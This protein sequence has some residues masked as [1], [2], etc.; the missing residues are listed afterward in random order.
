MANRASTD[1][2]EGRRTHPAPAVSGT[3]A[4][5]QAVNT[6]STPIPTISVTTADHIPNDA[7][8]ILNI[9]LSGSA[10]KVAAS[11]SD[12]I[13]MTGNTNAVDVADSADTRAIGLLPPPQQSGATHAAQRPFSPP[14]FIAPL[15]NTHPLNPA[16]TL[17]TLQPQYLPTYLDAPVPFTL[18]TPYHDRR[19]HITN[20]HNPNIVGYVMSHV[21]AHVLDRPVPP[22]LPSVVPRRSRNANSNPDTARSND[23]VNAVDATTAA[24]R[25]GRPVAQQRPGTTSRGTLRSEMIPGWDLS[26]AE[27]RATKTFAERKALSTPKESVTTIKGKGELCYILTNSVVNKYT[28]ITEKAGKGAVE[29]VENVEGYLGSCKFSEMCFWRRKEGGR[30]CGGCGEEIGWR[31]DLIIIGLCCTLG[32]LCWDCFKEVSCS[33][34]SLFR[35][36]CAIFSCAR[37]RLIRAL[38]KLC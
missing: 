30:W 23:V 15:L 16:T 38:G 6:T 24:S 31:T 7:Q 26:P 33:F 21:P 17:P 3:T 22:S 13:S 36:S 11:T 10:S 9:S 35:V 8:P 18:N 27:Q 14:T 25:L 20:L 5:R 34:F 28:L 4:D 37:C 32:L 29:R 1:S 2:F 19:Q 12:A